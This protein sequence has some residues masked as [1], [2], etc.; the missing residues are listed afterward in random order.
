VILCIFILFKKIKGWLRAWQPVE[1]KHINM[2]S[3]KL[4]T[5]LIQACLLT[6]YHL[7]VPRRTN[8][9]R[10]IIL[11]LFVSEIHVPS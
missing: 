10:C 9:S 5:I 4:Y 11:H 2:A 6:E 7:R 3:L 8:E 1:V